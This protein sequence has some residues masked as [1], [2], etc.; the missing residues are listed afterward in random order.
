MSKYLT[1]LTLIATTLMV[2]ACGM[3]GTY[4]FTAN[5]KLI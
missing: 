5:M 2:S 1:A 3:N 4:A